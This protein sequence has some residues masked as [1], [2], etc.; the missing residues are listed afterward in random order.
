[1][2]IKFGAGRV[3]IGL[4]DEVEEDTWV[5]ADGSVMTQEDREELWNTGEPTNFGEEDCAMI[6][7]DTRKLHSTKCIN[8][9]KYVCEAVYCDN[10]PGN[11]PFS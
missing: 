7:S 4:T 3:W 9:Y 1:M 11:I 8:A 2:N 6:K 10:C 5:W